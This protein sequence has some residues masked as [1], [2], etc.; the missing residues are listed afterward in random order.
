M[1]LLKRIP[2]RLFT[3]LLFI[4]LFCGTSANAADE[5][6][7]ENY[8][9]PIFENVLPSLNF[10]K[11]LRFHGKST[12]EIKSQLEIEEGHDATAASDSPNRSRSQRI[13]KIFKEYRCPIAIFGLI[14]S[15]V[16]VGVIWNALPK[17]DPTG[18]CKI[19]KT[20]ISAA[21][22][23][24]NIFNETKV[25]N[26][27][28]R[29]NQLE[30]EN[31]KLEAAV[32]ASEKG[33]GEE[34][35]PS[36]TWYDATS[37]IDGYEEENTK[38]RKKS[39][40]GSFSI[41]KPGLKLKNTV[42]N[43]DISDDFRTNPMAKIS[44]FTLNNSVQDIS[45]LKQCVAYKILETVGEIEVPHCQLSHVCVNKERMGLYVSIEPLVQAFFERHLGH[46][47]IALYEGDV[48]GNG[49]LWERGKSDFYP[50]GIDTYEY[51]KGDRQWEQSQEFHDLLSL[52]D[53]PDDAQLS[54][55]EEEMV[56]RILDMPKILKFFAGEQLVHHWDGYAWNNN[57]N[58]FYYN[59]ENHKIAFLPWGTDQTLGTASLLSM[60][61]ADGRIFKLIL[62]SETFRMQ[63]WQEFEAMRENLRLELPSLFQFIDEQMEIMKPWFYGD[64]E[65]IAVEKSIKLKRVLENMAYS[66]E[67]FDES[68]MVN[69]L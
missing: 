43:P 52:I 55:D 20:P 10:H 48:T 46:N 60:S 22:L 23:A 45:Y 5:L 54:P 8:P 34:I 64:E 32:S 36:F 4:G 63:L 27:N 53:R 30:W 65:Q 12:E 51:K 40:Y 2:F 1:N 13:K 19:P 56:E 21:D 68:W 14:V 39:W 61:S 33:I 37:N 47:D 17:D 24:E 3:P 44:K 38:I 18:L 9:K 66:K 29:M 31:L 50:D 25:L 58:F 62:K 69:R 6:S 16:A 15:S 7:N 35:L 28:V 42:Y 49:K 11:D 67:K 26:I 59:Y 57:N 41:T